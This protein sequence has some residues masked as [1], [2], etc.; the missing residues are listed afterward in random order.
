ML[1]A[2]PHSPKLCGHTSSTPV[3]GVGGPARRGRWAGSLVVSFESP[4]L[5]QHRVDHHRLGLVQV[6]LEIRHEA[7]EF[8]GGQ[9][10]SL[11]DPPP[12]NLRE[13]EEL[14]VEGISQCQRW[15]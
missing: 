1:H 5:E 12:G 15:T 4:R 14:G 11:E 8:D 10:A 6:S 13:G 9:K 3:S 2:K 7:I